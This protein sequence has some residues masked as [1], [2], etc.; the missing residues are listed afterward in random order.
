MKKIVKSALLMAAMMLVSKVLGLL[1]EVFLA[2]Q[3]GTSY[4]VD[5]YTVACTLPTV[6]FTLFASGF[7]NSYLPVYMRINEAER[8]N[9]F[10]SRSRKNR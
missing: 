5:A 8:K 10:F 4:I 9:Y 6:L 7:S 3:F 2:Q 1:R